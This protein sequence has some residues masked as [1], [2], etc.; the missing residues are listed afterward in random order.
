MASDDAAL[1]RLFFMIIPNTKRHPNNTKTD[2]LPISEVI[3]GQGRTITLT[4]SMNAHVEQIRF[5]NM[6]VNRKCIQPTGK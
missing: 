2:Q 5:F 1:A 4:T 6:L 3:T